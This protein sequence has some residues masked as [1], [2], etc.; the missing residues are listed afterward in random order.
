MLIRG[1]L[2]PGEGRGS[3]GNLTASRNQAGL[4]IRARVT[5]VNPKSPGQ[6]AIRQAMASNSFQWSNNLTNSQRAAWEAYAEETPL[7][8]KLG[9]LVNTSGRQMYL[10][11]NNARVQA[12]IGRIDTAPPTPGVAEPPISL[13][14]SNTTD[15]VIVALTDPGLVDNDVV[16]YT[17]G[18]PVNFAKNFY[19]S[20]YRTAAAAVAIT[21]F[22]LELKPAPEVF[23]DQKYFVESR[24]FLTNGKVSFKVRQSAETIA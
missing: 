3:A 2:G 19:S 8:N 1:I 9:D 10:R 23:I 13:L 7:P 24:L 5:P 12:G 16:I 14:D 20:P 22:P 11:T 6:V 21:P 15:G 18:N 17:I 4:Y